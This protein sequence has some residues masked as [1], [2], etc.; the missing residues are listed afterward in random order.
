MKALRR[1]AAVLAV[2][3]ISLLPC[4]CAHGAPAA[5]TEQEP[6]LESI[7][8]DGGTINEP[9]SAERYSYTFTLSQPG[10][11]PLLKSYSITAGRLY[12]TY[13]SNEAGVETGVVATVETQDARRV[14]RFL[15]SNLDDIVENSDTS[16]ASI[17]FNC[18]YLADDIY[19]DMPRYRLYIPADLTVLNIYPVANDEN[20]VCSGPFEFTLELDQSPSVNITVTASDKTTRTYTFQTIRV[21]LNQAQFEQC[22]ENGDVDTILASRPFFSQ[23]GV[24]I[25]LGAGIFGLVVLLIAVPVCRRVLLRTEPPDDIAFF[26]GE[27]DLGD[28][29]NENDSEAE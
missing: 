24:R 17:E 7:S 19:E 12:I 13:E 9:F 26:A 16:L 6:Y 15:Y 14:Y 10:E 29:E 1:A 27:N 8:F 25:A 11:R 28:E 2:V 3:F 5:Q 18:A 22:L 20:A 23:P 21:T 4:F